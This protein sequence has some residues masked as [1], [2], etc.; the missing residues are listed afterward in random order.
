MLRNSLE[1]EEVKDAGADVPVHLDG[2][3]LLGVSVDNSQYS[4][5]F[6]A[7]SPLDHE[8]IAPDVILVLWSESNT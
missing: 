6:A 1:H 7:S 5:S 4:E 2:K 3:T 8:V